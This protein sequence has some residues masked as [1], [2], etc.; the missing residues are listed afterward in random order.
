MTPFDYNSDLNISHEDVDVQTDVNVLNNWNLSLSEIEASILNRYSVNSW[1]ELPVKAKNKV[2]RIYLF[3]RYV[4]SR[5]ASLLNEERKENGYQ[6]E[7]SRR[8]DR[9]LVAK[10]MEV[11]KRELPKDVYNHILSI[12]QDR[13]LKKK[14]RKKTTNFL[15]CSIL[16]VNLQCYNHSD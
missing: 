12:A 1:K 7:R 8:K 3:R 11:A 10:F 5:I 14:Y 6:S 2:R 4:R 15:H 9:T 16:F 13:L